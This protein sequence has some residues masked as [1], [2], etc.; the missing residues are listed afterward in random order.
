MYEQNVLRE[1]IKKRQDRDVKRWGSL[2]PSSK[3]SSLDIEMALRKVHTRYF[4]GKND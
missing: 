1:L 3:L 4:E 2:R